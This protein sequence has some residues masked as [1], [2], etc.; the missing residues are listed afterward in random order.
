MAV[1]GRGR[2]Y[3]K[4]DFFGE[5]VKQLGSWAVQGE[6]QSK[7]YFI[8]G[9]VT[10]TRLPLMRMRPQS[11]AHGTVLL[12]FMPQKKGVFLQSLET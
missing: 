6:P 7:L 5:L 11:S 12:A 10:T 3:G 2:I 4:T 1:L 8:T 9:S